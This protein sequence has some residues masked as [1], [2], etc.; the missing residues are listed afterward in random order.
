MLKKGVDYRV[1]GFWPFRRYQIIK[2]FKVKT[3]IIPPDGK[4]IRTMFGHLNVK[5]VLTIKA[6]F[7]YDGA[8]GGKDTK[9]FMRGACVHDWGCNAINAGLLPAKP[10]QKLFDDLLKETI[11]KDGMN[12]FRAGYV[13]KAVRLFSKLKH[14]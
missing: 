9:T 5:G 13:H 3:G 1:F 2:G 14:N 10:Y 11:K 4:P 12:F 8:T 7:V 6:G